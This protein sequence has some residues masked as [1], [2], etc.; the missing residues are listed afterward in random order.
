MKMFP[1]EMGT[2]FQKL[3]MGFQKLE[4][5]FQKLEA[6]YEMLANWK[7]VRIIKKEYAVCRSVYRSVT[8]SKSVGQF[9]SKLLPN[10]TQP[11][12]TCIR[13]CF[14]VRIFFYKN[15]KCQLFFIK[16]YF[17]VYQIPE[18]SY[19]LTF[20]KLATNKHCISNKQTNKQT[21]YSLTE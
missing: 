11:I 2:G 15:V 18:R 7:H 21:I 6:S 12:L 3:E 17:H 10:T 19:V 20:S 9:A 4:T 1:R 8:T 13:P 16:V 14:S 5:S